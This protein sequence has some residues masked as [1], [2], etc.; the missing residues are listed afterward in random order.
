MLDKEN[1]LMTERLSSKVGA[2]NQVFEPHHFT[3][4]ISEHP[5]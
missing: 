4:H 3:V 1:Q 5:S 2:L